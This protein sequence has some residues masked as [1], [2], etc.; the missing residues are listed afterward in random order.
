MKKLILLVVGV[1]TASTALFAQNKWRVDKAHA[2]IGFTVRH[3]M[4]S[5]VDGYFKKFDAAIISSK[6]DFSD[7]VFDVTIEVA[8]INTD[9]DT[10]DNDLRSAKYFDAAKYPEI[11]FKST[12]VEKKGENTFKVT[13]NLTI[14]G[15]TRLTTLEV[16]LNGTSISAATHKPAAGFKVSGSIDRTDFKVGSVP[17]AMIGDKVELKASGEFEQE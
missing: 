15:I 4:F 13:G 11:T 7:A 14:H 10:R 1:L 16:K 6:P 17:A 12:S 8:S 9:N 5:D 2:K 3:M